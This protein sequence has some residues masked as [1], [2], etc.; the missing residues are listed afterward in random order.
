MQKR[1]NNRKREQKK[2]QMQISA[3]KSLKKIEISDLFFMNGEIAEFKVQIPRPYAFFTASA[4][5]FARAVPSPVLISTVSPSA[6]LP[7]AKAW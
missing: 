5:S 2:E 4:K 1:Q 7:S 3:K 6:I